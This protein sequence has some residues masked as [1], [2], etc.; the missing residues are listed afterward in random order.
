MNSQPAVE[1]ALLPAL[2]EADEALARARPRP[3]LKQNILAE[4]D[5]KAPKKQR[6]Q[7]IS[8]WAFAGAIL[9][10]IAYV[11]L[12]IDDGPHHPNRRA[13]VEPNHP[14]VETVEPSPTDSAAQPSLRP[15]PIQ[16]EP[17][18]EVR[19]DLNVA[20][21]SPPP[22]PTNVF[23]QPNETLAPTPLPSNRQF[24]GPVKPERR[25]ITPTPPKSAPS[26]SSTART[27]LDSS[28]FAPWTNA[29]ARQSKQPEDPFAGLSTG[30]GPDR[31]R[32]TPKSPTNPPA[33]PPKN[34]ESPPDKPV[35]DAE[36]A[37]VHLIGIYEGNGGTAN[38]HLAR[39]GPALL[40]LSAYAATTWTVTMTSDVE[41]RAVILLGYEEQK[42]NIGVDVVE[43]FVSY[44]KSGEFL[45]CGYEWPDL[46]PNS[47]C[48]T[49]EL[50]ANI[51]EAFGLSP[52]SFSGC[53]AGSTFMLS[54]N[55]ASG[56]CA[57]G[58]PFSSFP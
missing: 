11:V 19:P 15:L 24:P 40:V 7:T 1:P 50:I 21:T 46:D 34:N 22:A 20:P 37:E 10:T 54:E 23:P 5:R 17:R 9:A 58:Y 42:L 18:P 3:Q 49:G 44:E 45:G 14:I 31:P 32:H 29:P 4:F 35:F 56:T 12:S 28:V 38:V 30:G 8:A 53:Y 36:G 2:R 51:K 52:S 48:E 13:F 39:P 47:G 27:K 57:G 55:G 6:R 26:P 33:T 41:L 43:V 16:K 25:L